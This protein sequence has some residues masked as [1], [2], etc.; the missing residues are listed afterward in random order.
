MFGIICGVVES[1]VG[2]EDVEIG[3]KY[4]G[5][6]GKGGGKVSGEVVLVDMGV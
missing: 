6:V 5:V 2:V 4:L 3:E 1:M